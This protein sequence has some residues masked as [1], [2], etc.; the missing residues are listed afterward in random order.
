MIELDKITKIRM[1]CENLSLLKWKYLEDMMKDLNPEKTILVGYSYGGS[2]VLASKKKYKK[3]I[4]FAP[5]VYAKVEPMPPIWKQA[6]K[7]KMSH[8]KDLEEFQG[9]WTENPSEVICVHRDA[10]WVVPFANS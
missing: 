9:S 2:I 1:R 6:S 3:V 10:D 8:Q 7:E 4:L 5:A